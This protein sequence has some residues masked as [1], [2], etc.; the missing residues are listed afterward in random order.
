MIAMVWIQ[1]HAIP[2]Q[3]IDDVVKARKMAILWLEN[4]ASGRKTERVDFYKKSGSR[5]PY[6][7]VM[8]ENFASGRSYYW[9]HYTKE[10][11][12]VQAPLFKNGKIQR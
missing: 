4:N 6:A 11:G 7:Y 2:R 9:H 1:N 5:E 10:Y 3:Y 8:M 12:M